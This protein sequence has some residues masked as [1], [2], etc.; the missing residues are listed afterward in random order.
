M[1]NYWLEPLKKLITGSHRLWSRQKDLVPGTTQL[2]AGHLT[3]THHTTATSGATQKDTT[4]P[5]VSVE[6][7]NS[8]WWIKEVYIWADANTGRGPNVLIDVTPVSHRTVS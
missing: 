4:P 3:T 2:S 7:L 5:N 1:S 8:K 6:L